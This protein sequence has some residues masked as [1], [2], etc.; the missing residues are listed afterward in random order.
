[1]QK[2]VWMLIINCSPFLLKD[3]LSALLPMQTWTSFML[4]F[5]PVVHMPEHSI[6]TTAL[7]RT[8]T[9]VLYIQKLALYTTLSVFFRLLVF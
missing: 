3:S 1:M 2:A 6:P 7:M 9:T 5:F 8:E 4:L